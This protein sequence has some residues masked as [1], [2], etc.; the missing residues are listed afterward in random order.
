VNSPAT[1]FW[2]SGAAVR[3]ST[4]KHT[5]NTKL[6]HQSLHAVSEERHVEVHKEA[7]PMLRQLEVGQNLRLM[8]IGRLE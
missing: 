8:L 5:K 6:E 3:L 1:T 2:R 4:T 7:E